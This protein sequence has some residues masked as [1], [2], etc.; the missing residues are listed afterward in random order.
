ML[1]RDLLDPAVCFPSDGLTEGPPRPYPVKLVFTCKEHESCKRR[2]VQRA[3]AH[4][5]RKQR[6]WNSLEQEL[7]D[8]PLVRSFFCV[9]AAK[10][11]G[12][13]FKKKTF[14]V[15]GTHLVST[16]FNTNNESKKDLKAVEAVEASH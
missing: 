8:R 5:A 13:P 10:E 14:K 11:S 12:G 4:K 16:A 1:A 3:T 2:P 9:Q 15:D 6:N 7:L